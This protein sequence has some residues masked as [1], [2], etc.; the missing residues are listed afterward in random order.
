MDRRVIPVHS[1]DDVEMAADLIA[2]KLKLKLGSGVQKKRKFIA[3][4]NPNID[5][6]DNRGSRVRTISLV[7][8][9]L[10]RLIS[11][12]FGAGIQDLFS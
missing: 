2:S 1:G 12:R 8:L 3:I 6:R 11:V 10:C 7:W 5:T 9:E 4:L